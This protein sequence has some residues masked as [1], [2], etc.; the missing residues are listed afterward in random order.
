MLKGSMLAS[1]IKLRRGA[2]I[3]LSNKLIRC[4]LNTLI[5]S[6]A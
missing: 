3:I 2:I 6:E 5:A 1:S 4:K